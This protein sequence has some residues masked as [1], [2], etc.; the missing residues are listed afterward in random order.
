METLQYFVVIGDVTTDLLSNSH[1]VDM[2]REILSCN[3]LESLVE[4]LTRIDSVFGKQ[5]YL[6]H[7][8]FKAKNP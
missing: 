3:G 7:I 6:N 2:Y 8:L 1:L 5:S 4:S